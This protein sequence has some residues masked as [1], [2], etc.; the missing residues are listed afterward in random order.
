MGKP[1]F[2]SVEFAQDSAPHPKMDII[3]TKDCLRSIA[4]HAVEK[5]CPLILRDHPGITPMLRYIFQ[6]KPHLLTLLPEDTAAGDIITR[7]KPAAVFFI[8][9]KDQV[10]RDYAALQQHPAILSLPL[11]STGAA[12][13]TIDAAMRAANTLPQTLAEDHAFGFANIGKTFILLAGGPA[14]RR[15]Q[16]PQP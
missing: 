5:D 1:V 12:A 3:L 16:A 8:A 13:H 4:F 7:H 2:I 10:M 11:K 15:Q 14:G 6:D 9:G